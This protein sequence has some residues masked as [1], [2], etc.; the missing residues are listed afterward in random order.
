MRTNQT[1]RRESK[2]HVNNT[3]YTYW[4]FLSYSHQDNLVHRKDGTKDCVQWANWLHGALEIYRIPKSFHQLRMMTDEPMPTRFGPI[5]RDEAELP[6]NA[7]LAES[8]RAAL[9]ASRFLI[10]ICSPRS[11]GSVYVNEEVRYFKELGRK[12]RILTL[13]VDGEPN[14][15]FGNKG[16]FS[17]QDEC[18]CPALIYQFTANG[19]VIEGPG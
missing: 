1:F 11:A 2:V 5:F 19:Q 12:N 4:A 14:A 15:C 9:R 10:V 13:I 18:F 8:V 17:A 6:I 7:D 16:G 3:G